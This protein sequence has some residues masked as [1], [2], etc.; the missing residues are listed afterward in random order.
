MLISLLPI[1]GCIQNAV[2]LILFNMTH[3]IKNQ[4]SSDKGLRKLHLIFL[5]SKLIISKIEYQL[6]GFVISGKYEMD[7]EFSC[8]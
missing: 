1:P 8:L 5:F 2:F 3:K 4:Y 6:L 7:F